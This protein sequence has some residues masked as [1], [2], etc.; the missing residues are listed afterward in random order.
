MYTHA[1]THTHTHTHTCT[2][3]HSSTRCCTASHQKA[4]HAADVSGG[5]LGWSETVL[6]GHGDPA[7]GSGQSGRHQQENPPL[8]RPGYLHAKGR[9]IGPQVNVRDTACR[10]HR[11]L[12]W[13]PSNFNWG[14]RRAIIDGNALVI[15]S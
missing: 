13:Q 2:H 7:S 9:G 6:G 14:T 15:S 12:L 5:G 4:N 3:T 8:Q 10:K 11:P 1:H